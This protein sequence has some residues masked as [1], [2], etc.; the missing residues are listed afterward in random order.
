MVMSWQRR[1]NVAVM[2]WHGNVMVQNECSNITIYSAVLTLHF[3]SNFN[4]W[5]EIAD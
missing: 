4:S 1:G 5:T 2:F 3:V